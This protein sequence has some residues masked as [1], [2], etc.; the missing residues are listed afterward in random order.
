MGGAISDPTQSTPLQHQ[1]QFGLNPAGVVVE[2]IPRV[3]VRRAF[4]KL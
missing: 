3:K 1:A 4:L 2:K